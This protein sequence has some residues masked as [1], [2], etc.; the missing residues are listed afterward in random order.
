MG[1]WGIWHGEFSVEELES[2]HEPG[3]NGLGRLSLSE[4]KA[5]DG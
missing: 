1:I 5:L 3:W 2:N 4:A